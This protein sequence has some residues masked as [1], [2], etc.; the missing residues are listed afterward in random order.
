MLKKS[1]YF[2]IGLM[3]KSVLKTGDETFNTEIKS[4]C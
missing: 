1:G 3:L 4:L 2:S